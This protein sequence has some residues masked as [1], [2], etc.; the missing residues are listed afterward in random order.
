M[1][2]SVAAEP[3][4]AKAPARKPSKFLA[5]VR[6]YAVDYYVPDYVPAD[7]D[8]VVCLSHPAGRRAPT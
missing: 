7:T 5:G 3:V 1:A 4:A 8:S 2:A 6:P